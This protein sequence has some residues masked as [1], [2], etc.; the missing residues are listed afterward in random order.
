MTSV[1]PRPTTITHILFAC[2]CR[3]AYEQVLD[4]YWNIIMGDSV[5]YYSWYV[6]T[7][8]HARKNKIW[9]HQQCT[10]VIWSNAP[11]R[12]YFQ[13][14]SKMNVDCEQNGFIK[15]VLETFQ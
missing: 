3:E 6:T 4:I 8:I 12:Y 5:R 2:E 9:N 7:D 11:R 15:K 10:W 1:K 13:E 14:G